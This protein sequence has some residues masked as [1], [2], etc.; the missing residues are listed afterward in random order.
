M[1]VGVLRSREPGR[2]LG[3]LPGSPRYYPAYQVLKII[4]S[5][6]QSSAPEDGHNEVRNM[7]SQWIINLIIIVASSWSHTSFH[8]N[9]ARS[10]GHQMSKK[11]ICE[12]VRQNMEGGFLRRR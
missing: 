2:A 1:L 4:C 5:K 12:D 10:H 9:D 8:I 7:L 11:F 3:L 6:I